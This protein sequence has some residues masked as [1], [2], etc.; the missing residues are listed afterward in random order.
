MLFK[1]SNDHSKLEAVGFKD[2]EADSKLEKDLEDLLA[3]HMIDSLFEGRPLMPF[4]QE[5][6]GQAEADIYALDEAGDIVIFEIKRSTAGAGALD[7]LFRYTQDAGRWS[8]SD[9][10]KR[11]AGY[12]KNDLHEEELRFAHKR[13]FDL[14]TTLADDQFNRAQHMLV[15]G[16][17]ADSELMRAVDFW[18]RKGISID[19]LPYRLYHIS[20]HLYFEFFAKPYDVHV[21]PSDIKGVLFDTNRTYDENSLQSMVEKRRIS[22]Y[23]DRKDAVRS[24]NRRDIVFYSHVGNGLVAAARVVGRDVKVDQDE[25][26]WDVEFLTPVPTR[27]DQIKA[28]PFHQVKAVTGKSFYWARIQKV[29][30]LSHEEA[31][32]LLKELITVLNG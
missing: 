30:Y 9:I 2:F 10:H 4:H 22:A 5:R 21:N 24:L 8:Y 20:E 28:M 31:D 18:K 26:Y 27:F 11:S 16:S 3:N 15:V 12:L 17:A 13:A 23:G 29:P 25:L 32:L 19:F 7:Q 1:L 6:Q 14:D